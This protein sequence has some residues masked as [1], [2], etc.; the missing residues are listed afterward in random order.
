[1]GRVEKLVGVCSPPIAPKKLVGLSLCRFKFVA[2]S[3]NNILFIT[4][5][6]GVLYCHFDGRQFMK[7]TMYQITVI[8]NTFWILEQKNLKGQNKG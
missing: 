7:M 2:T 3:A 8:L 1:M 6:V 4:S 5:N